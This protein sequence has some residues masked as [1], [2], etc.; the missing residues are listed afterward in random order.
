MSK[1]INIFSVL[2]AG[3]FVATFQPSPTSAANN[4]KSGAVYALINQVNNAVAVYDRA[5]D[6][7]LSI[8]R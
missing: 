3:A 1:K 4:L 2:I 8:D 7:S 6:G 5:P